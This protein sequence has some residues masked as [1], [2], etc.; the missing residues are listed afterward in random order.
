MNAKSNNIEGLHKELSTSAQTHIDFNDDKHR[1][2]IN[3]YQPFRVLLVDDD[4]VFRMT[5]KTMLKEGFE[6]SEVDSGE[7][8]IEYLN[9]H[10]ID[11][12]LLDLNMPGMSGLE[13]LDKMK[14]RVAKNAIAVI[15]LS[16]AD[17]TDDIKNAFDSGAV[18]YLTK[19]VKKYELIARVNTHLELRLRQLHLED[20]VIERTS[21][22]LKANEDL[23][24]AQSQ[25]LQSE[26]MASIGQLAAGVAHEI[27]NPVGYVASNLVSLKSYVND[28]FGLVDVYE[29]MESSLS[30]EQLEK[31][32]ALKNDVDLD[33]LKSDL[34]EL[35]A[36]TED[37]V[38][39]VREI[40]LS[41]KE[42]SHIGEN[43]WEYANLHEGID[44]TLN[45]VHNEIKYK[46]VV[47]K[48]YGDIE[49]VQCIPSQINQ[50]FMNFLVNAAHAIEDKG[51]ITIATL[52]EG[53]V[54]KIM[55]SDNG[56][57][58]PEDKQL[59]IF[60]P[61]FTT[62]PVGK[63]TGLGLSL[64]FQIVE[65]HH[66]HIDLKSEVGVGTTFTITLPIQQ[67]EDES[68]IDDLDSD[69]INA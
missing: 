44:S 38:S 37:G 67:P 68:E 26:K 16:A 40:V 47:N 29:S 27:N 30:D 3:R 46:A 7:A 52:Q 24:S 8:A 6:F 5:I 34:S 19:P 1:F 53:D 14:D 9:G 13:V 12:M 17:N 58:I 65:K 56:C 32:T 21:E 55:L 4:P 61:F 18:D 45:I 49:N 63:G 54:V 33:Y 15:F 2:D 39:R 31:I 62:K 23:E 69:D 51:E 11:I 48:N 10:D 60:D 20:M 25:L 41:L 35:L 64:S 28:V 66:G 42:F 22:L 57:G 59:K 36:E 50:V 43:R